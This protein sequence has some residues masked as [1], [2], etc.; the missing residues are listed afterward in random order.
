MLFV[1]CCVL[2][3]GWC[4]PLLFVDWCLVFVGCFLLVVVRCVL[5]VVYCVGV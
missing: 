2:F 3:V 4:L 1:V 5:C